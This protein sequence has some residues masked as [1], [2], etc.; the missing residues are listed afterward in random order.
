[1]ARMT[2]CDNCATKQ[3]ANQRNW[4]TITISDNTRSLAEPATE[5]DL[6]RECA[7]TLAAHNDW[8]FL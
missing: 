3:P 2:V 6:C 4:Y 5:Y 8:I 1:M 7:E